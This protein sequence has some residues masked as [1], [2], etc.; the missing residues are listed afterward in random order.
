MKN[1][2][3]FSIQLKTT[4]CKYKHVVDAFEYSIQIIRMP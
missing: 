4:E 2:K 1:V 3:V